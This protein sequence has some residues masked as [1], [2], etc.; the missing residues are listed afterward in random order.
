M[1]N[2]VLQVY[3]HASGQ[4][5]NRDKSSVYFSNNTPNRKRGEIGAALGVKQVEKF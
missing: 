4:C 1:L 3:A 5:I 2:E